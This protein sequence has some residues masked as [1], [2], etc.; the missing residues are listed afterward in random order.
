MRK[1]KDLELLQPG[2]LNRLFTHIRKNNNKGRNLYDEDIR[3]IALYLY[4]LS[5]RSAYE[6]WQKNLRGGLPSVPSCQSYL[7]KCKRTDEGEILFERIA[8]SLKKNNELPFIIIGEDDTK[9]DER[10]RYDPRNN[11]IV[12]I[13]LP[14]DNNGV[15]IRGSF[16]FTTL[17]EAR[18]YLDNYQTTS[19]AKLLT[20]RSLTPGS[21]TYHLLIYGTRGSDKATD[22]RPRWKFI[23]G[24]FAKLGITV[25][26]K[27][28]LIDSI[29]EQ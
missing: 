26:G 15:P 12:G 24:E 10:P 16:K 29:I 14:L 2:F 21:K 28:F 1:T 6:V 17:A 19:Y 23:F 11:E 5:G 13:Q 3:E 20:A 7:K 18:S 4:T 22:V 27:I 9:I 25:V 8:E